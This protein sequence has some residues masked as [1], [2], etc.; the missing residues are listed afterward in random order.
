M[1][2]VYKILVP[3]DFTSVAETALN[4]AIKIAGIM[5]GEIVLLH[6]V[7]R[8][9]KIDEARDQVDPIAEKVS[10]EYNIPTVLMILIRLQIMK[11]HD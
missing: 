6:V 2:D 5:E 3:T 9:S 4:H 11:A 1:K 10:K 7:D 8:D